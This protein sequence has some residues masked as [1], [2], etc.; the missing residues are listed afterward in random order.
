MVPH[1]L[2]HLSSQS[3][4]KSLPKVVLLV[5]LFSNWCIR[6]SVALWYIKYL[7]LATDRETLLVTVAMKNLL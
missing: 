7:F 2:T 1:K 5:K 4:S 3:S 6:R